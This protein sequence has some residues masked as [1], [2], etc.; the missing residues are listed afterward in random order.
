MFTYDTVAFILKAGFGIGA[1]RNKI[2]AMKVGTSR[3]VYMGYR[4]V[5]FM[6]MNS[7]IPKLGT[8]YW[9]HLSLVS[10]VANAHD[11]DYFFHS[12]GCRCGT[13]CRPDYRC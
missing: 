2:K 11:L 4:K 6:S 10:V 9:F 5:N 7:I 1:T 13:G 8:W 12:G 3:Q